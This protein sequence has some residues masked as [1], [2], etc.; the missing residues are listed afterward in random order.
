MIGLGSD[1]N[2]ET[3]KERQG[4]EEKWRGSEQETFKVTGMGAGNL[5]CEALITMIV[6]LSKCLLTKQ[7]M[8]EEETGGEGKWRGSE[9]ESKVAGM[10]AGN[11]NCEAVMQSWQDNECSLSPADDVH[12]C[13]FF[14]IYLDI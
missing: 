2:L 4:W 5:N 13:V 1:K 11:L 10:G 9:Q 12:M 8:Q 14:Y 3:K 6:T 7:E